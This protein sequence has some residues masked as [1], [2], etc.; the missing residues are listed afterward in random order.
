MGLLP[1]IKGDTF[2]G[3]FITINLNG[4]PIDLTDVNIRSHFRLGSKSGCKVKKFDLDNGIVV[5]DAVNG[6]FEM[7]VDTL[8]DWDAGSWVFDV[9]IEFPDG[10]IKT[11]YE[12]TLNVIQDITHA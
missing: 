2:N 6:Q 8:I 9:E 1:H 4:V 10:T 11:Y 7:L 12:D 3:L 5:T